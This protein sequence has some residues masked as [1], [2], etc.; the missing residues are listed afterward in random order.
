MGVQ[1]VRALIDG[2]ELGSTTLPLFARE[3]ASDGAD[4]LCISNI[5]VEA[6]ANPTPEGC[7]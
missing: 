6:D 7:D 4:N 5:Y 3:D 2:V 1:S